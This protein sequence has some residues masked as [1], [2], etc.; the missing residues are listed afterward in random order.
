MSDTHFEAGEMEV[1]GTLLSADFCAKTDLGVP[2]TRV[3]F[4]I[5]ADTAGWGSGRY[6]I[7]PEAMA[8]EFPGCIHYGCPICAGSPTPPA[9]DLAAARAEGWKAGAA[10]TKAEAVLWL[11]RAVRGYA[12]DAFRMDFEPPTPPDAK[13]APERERLKGW[14]N[15]YAG[16]LVG[17]TYDSRGEAAEDALSTPRRIACIDLSQHYV[18]E[19][20]EP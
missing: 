16:F 18:G 3:T 9:D 4:E 6:V 8:R 7:Q 10:A 17:T 13:P 19:G 11:G 12:S 14:V 5:P 15:V 20:L 2:A 1:T